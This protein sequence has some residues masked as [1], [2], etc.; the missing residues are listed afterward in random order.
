MHIDMN[1]ETGFTELHMINFNSYF[2]SADMY[3]DIEQ[4]KV[5]NDN[6]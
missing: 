1:I 4:N 2:M 3:I 6:V 5:H